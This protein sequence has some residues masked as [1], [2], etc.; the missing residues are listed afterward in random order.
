MYEFLSF[1]Q[2]RKD[3]QG[4]RKVLYHPNITCN[5]VYL[6]LSMNNLVQAI[7][8]RCE[9]MH[10]LRFHKLI[11]SITTNDWVINQCFNPSNHIL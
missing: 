6:L 2:L 8:N 7:K 5:T 3:T 4:S 9:V 1:P 10:L 11:G